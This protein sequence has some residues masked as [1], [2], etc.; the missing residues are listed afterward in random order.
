MQKQNFNVEQ[1]LSFLPQIP[2]AISFTHSF[3][4]LD[5][6]FEKWEESIFTIE[7]LGEFRL[8]GHVKEKC[9]QN[10]QCNCNCRNCY[11][12]CC[13][14]NFSCLTCFM[15]CDCVCC[16]SN[17]EVVHEYQGPIYILQNQLIRFEH[18][19]QISKLYVKDTLVLEFYHSFKN[20]ADVLYGG[21][22]SNYPHIVFQQPLGK[23][24]EKVYFEALGNNCPESCWSCFPYLMMCSWCGIGQLER[25]IR[26]SNS[27]QYLGNITAKRDKKKAC[28]T[29]CGCNNH[30]MQFIDYPDFT[31]DFKN[32]CQLDKLGI[33]MSTIHFTLYD[34]WRRFDW[35]GLLKM[36]HPVL[37]YDNLK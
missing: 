6:S 13:S 3:E 27:Q 25:K 18:Y 4:F 34:R 21:C 2:D 9:C 11:Y 31:I 30:C 15:C 20:L 32:T 7:S 10:A 17:Y 14:C 5:K 35:N 23:A 22:K 24:N 33:I 1:A 36:N 19:G 37:F 16:C 28:L 26:V 12:G 29:Q 8:G